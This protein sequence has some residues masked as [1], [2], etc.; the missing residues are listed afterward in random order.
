MGLV[1]QMELTKKW[2]SS[3]SRQGQW[4]EKQVLLRELSSIM[5][6]KWLSTL[7]M[8]TSVIPEIPVISL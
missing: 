4:H 2:Q 3:H 5:I 1:N 8:E 7:Y 6:H